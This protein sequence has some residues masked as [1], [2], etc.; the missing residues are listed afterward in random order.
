MTCNRNCRTR[1][2]LSPDHLSFLLWFRP[3]SVSEMT[4]WIYPIQQ[5]HRQRG[6]PGQTSPNSVLNNGSLLTTSEPALV[7]P[8]RTPPKSADAD[9]RV[10]LLRSAES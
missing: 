10:T 3:E 1:F 5:W 4:T 8:S 7:S 2:S 9:E 6:T